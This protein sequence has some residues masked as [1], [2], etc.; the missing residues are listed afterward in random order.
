MHGTVT[1][2]GCMS[3]HDGV[4][5]RWDKESTAPAGG[6]EHPR[7]I[8]DRS[9]SSVNMALC[10]VSSSQDP[11]SGVDAPVKQFTTSAS[12]PLLRLFA[13]SRLALFGTDAVRPD[14]LLTNKNSGY[15]KTKDLEQGRKS[16]IQTKL[17]Y[18]KQESKTAHV[19]PK[20]PTPLLYVV[21]CIV[22]RP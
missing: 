7:V 5:R 1:C 11:W 19:F 15:R 2:A 12:S 21:F 14:Y 22:A 4:L 18:R 9:H 8:E 10:T 6:S 16:W 3:G 17:T 13:S 20:D